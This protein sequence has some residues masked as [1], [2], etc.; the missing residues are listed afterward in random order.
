MSV[1][2]T[3]ALIKEETTEAFQVYTATKKRLGLAHWKISHPK[4]LLQ[5]LGKTVQQFLLKPNMYLPPDPVISL[6]SIYLMRVRARNTQPPAHESPQQGY[7][8]QLKPRKNPRFIVRRRNRQNSARNKLW[9]HATM[10]M[11]LKNVALVDRYWR[12]VGF[13]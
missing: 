13:H 1:H 11:H 8:P 7:S 10:W 5:L 4:E 9:I 2:Y 12:A 3:P 6:P